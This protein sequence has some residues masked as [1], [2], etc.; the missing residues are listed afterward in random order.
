M[1]Q[2]L[3]LK[4]LAPLVL[5]V[6]GGL[7]AILG[8][9]DAVD[10]TEFIRPRLAEVLAQHG[11]RKPEI[12]IDRVGVVDVRLILAQRLGRGLAEE[13]PGRA[14]GEPMLWEGRCGVVFWRRAENLLRICC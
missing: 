2:H 5:H 7:E 10:E 1:H 13:L 12:K 8:E 6:Q 14:P 3:E 11:M 9:G 4:V